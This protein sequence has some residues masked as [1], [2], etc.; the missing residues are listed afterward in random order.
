[1]SAWC[2][3]ASLGLVGVAVGVGACAG[4]ALAQ[5]APPQQPA[6]QATQNAS[7]DCDQF[8]DGVHEVPIVVVTSPAPGETLSPENVTI[9]GFA[10][11][12]HVD[13]GAG[14]SRVSVF[15]GSR[16]AGG[17]PLGDATLRGP[18]PIPVVP[19]DQYASTS[20]WILKAQ[21]PLKPG[22]LNDV[23]VYARSELTN[24]ETSVKLPI[25]GAGAAAA[26]APL[27]SPEAGPAPPAPATATAVVEPVTEPMSLPESDA[28]APPADEPA[29]E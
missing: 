2:K 24:V 26:P 7:I 9:Q 16:E 23:F 13:V 8:A 12:C 5:V 28:P 21:A 18:S 3:R 14:I 22:E 15:L 29:V 20:G 19:A 6:G 10:V 1:V 17:I 25:M 4:S 27:P 11:D